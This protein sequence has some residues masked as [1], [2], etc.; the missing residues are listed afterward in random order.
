VQFQ[1]F[2]NF[3]YLIISIISAF[4]EIWPPGATANAG[5]L[6]FV[7]LVTA[8]KEAVEDYNRHKA[9]AIMNGTPIKVFE[10]G[11]WAESTWAKVAPSLVP[12]PRLLLVTHFHTDYAGSGCQAHEQRSSPG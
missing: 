3:F 1:R 7:L 8:L 6:A 5:P 9:D 4:P 2:A 12:L 10:G 11:R